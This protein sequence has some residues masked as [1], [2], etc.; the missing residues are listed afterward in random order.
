MDGDFVNVPP[1]SAAAMSIEDRQ[2]QED[3]DYLLALSLQEE[4]KKE[5]EKFKE[6]ETFKTKEGLDR[7]TDEELAIKLQAEEDERSPTTPEQTPMK[8]SSQSGS[9]DQ[10]AKLDVRNHP[11]KKTAQSSHQQQQVTNPQPPPRSPTMPYM[12]GSRQTETRDRRRSD[13]PSSNR[14]DGGKKQS[15]SN[16]CCLS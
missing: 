9:V 12:Q 14:R 11:A 7:L 16:T 8:T 3:Q 2:S 5:A 10:V 15:V 6:W 13:D 1:K 4:N